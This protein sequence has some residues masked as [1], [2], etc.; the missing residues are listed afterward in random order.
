MIFSLLLS[1]YMYSSNK[2]IDKTVI[3]KHDQN[4]ILKVINGIVTIRGWDNNS[5]QIKGIVES[6]IN[7]LFL[8]SQGN[9]YLIIAKPNYKKVIRNTKKQNCYLDIYM[10]K[11]NNLSI[12]SNN[13]D[14]TINGL[15][16]NLDINSIGGRIQINAESGNLNL[17]TV[18]GNFSV[19]GSSDI[20]EGMSLNG[21]FIIEGNHPVLKLKTSNGNMFFKID[22]PKNINAFTTYGEINMEYKNIENT[23]MNIDNIHGITKLFLTGHEDIKLLI[24]SISGKILVDNLKFDEFI[25][26]NKEVNIKNKNGRSSI[27]IET[28]NGD[29]ILNSKK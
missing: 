16:S 9:N 23:N 1:Y 20:I 19:Y 18:S 11:N 7:E 3:I 22:S 29:I 15:K 4:I 25:K 24:K 10:P 13:A 21:L 26:K 8:K 2:N 27:F 6:G 28:L 17:Q 14:I 12:Q 5:I